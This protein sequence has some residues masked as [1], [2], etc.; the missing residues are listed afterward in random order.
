[1]Q[2]ASQQRGATMPGAYRRSL[3]FA[4]ILML[5][6]AVLHS[7]D[8]QLQDV[9][10]AYVQSMKAGD[11][12]GMA[13]LM[14]PASLAEFRLMLVPVLDLP[15][16]DEAVPQLL[17]VATVEDARALSDQGM[18][19]AFMQFVVNQEPGVAEAMNTAEVEILGRVTEAEDIHV[20]IRTTMTVQEV[21]MRQLDVVTFRQDNGMWRA[22]LAGNVTALAQIISN[23]FSAIPNLY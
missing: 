8:D 11:F 14:H 16:A 13:D 1:M 2:P 9:T 23:Q 12:A 10:N 17:G 22:V 19:A 15:G 6:P 3:V 7:Q 20:V 4:I 18:F 5:V 21:E